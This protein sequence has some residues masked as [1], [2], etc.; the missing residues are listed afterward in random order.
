[1][2]PVE[3]KARPVQFREL[4]RDEWARYIDLNVYGSLNCVAAVIEM[5][6]PSHPSP[7]VIQRISTAG[8]APL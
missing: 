8:T 5:E 1:M 4:P 6:S 3:D 7:A 2:S